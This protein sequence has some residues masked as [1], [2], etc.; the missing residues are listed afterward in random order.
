MKSEHNI[1][2]DVKAG[3]LEPEKALAKLRKFIRG[4]ETKTYRR[5]KR[6]VK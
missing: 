2:Q 4:E 5:V 1:W 3:K 6:L